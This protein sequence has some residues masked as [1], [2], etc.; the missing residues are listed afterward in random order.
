MRLSFIMDKM[1]ANTLSMINKQHNIN[2]DQWFQ[3]TDTA[4]TGRKD[5]EK[6]SYPVEKYR[7]SLEHGSSIPAGNFLDFFR[8]FPACSWRNRPVIFDLGGNEKKEGYAKQLYILMTLDGDIQWL[9]V[10]SNIFLNLTCPVLCSCFCPTFFFS[11]ADVFITWE[12][13]RNKI[14][15]SWIYVAATDIFEY[16]IR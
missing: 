9:S 5:T 3:R 7:K 8:W 1:G 6:S 10:L 11:L 13:R 14:R 2:P 4:E 16:I 12:K 15:Y